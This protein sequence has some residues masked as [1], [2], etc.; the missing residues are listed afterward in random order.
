[1][2]NPGTRL[3]GAG[4]SA[5]IAMGKA[6]LVG[7]KLA[8][9]HE[10]VLSPEQTEVEVA[11]FE[12]ALRISREQ[13]AALQAR[14]Q[15]VMGKDNAA[16]FDSH[17]ML[18]DDP[19]VVQRVVEQIRERRRNAEHVFQS[20]ISG[21][22]DMLSK[23]D[24][25]YIRDRMADIQDVAGRVIRNLQGHAP[26]DLSH[27]QERCIVVAHE[28]SPSDTA[29]IDR[30]HVLAFVTAIGS[31]TS[32]TAIMAR[33]MGI[34][35]VVGLSDG[36]A[37]IDDG[38]MLVV[39][40]GRGEV[41]V[42]PTAEQ[43]ASSEQRIRDQQA[44]LARVEAE[45]TLPAE[46]LDGFHVRLAANIEMAEEVGTLRQRLGVGVGLFRTEFLFVR[47]DGLCEEEEHF[48]TYR[49]VAEDIYPHSVI[50]RT[51]DIGGDKFL[52]HLKMPVELNPFLGMRA[53][54]FCLRR[55][56]VFRVQ[57]RAILRA[58]AFGK[59]RIMFP[60]I[61]TL[62]ELQ[63]ALGLLS[64]VKA[65]LAAE[66]VPHNPHLDVGMMIEVPSAA[67]IADKLAP[68]V[69]FFSLGTNDLV[70]YS[71]AVDRSNPDLSY[72]YQPSHPSIIRMI[73]HVAQA[74]YAHGKWLGVCGEMASEPLL[75]PLLLGLGIHELSMSPVSIPTI[76][77]LVRHLRMH[78]AETLV[79]RAVGCG[80][81]EEVLVLCRDFI[82]R[83]SPDLLPGA[84]P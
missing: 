11:R 30:D 64:E 44:W 32:H 77:Q 66:G 46:T 14:V 17:L 34:P 10:V 18:V 81:A 60:M 43:L 49:K 57:L 59:V 5:G 2:A 19:S 25:S 75:V 1:M 13:I 71:L 47:N 70:Q 20:V 8:Q 9:V 58:S 27:L 21:Y 35:A 16:I 72:L 15:E 69:D 3:K 33:A 63:Q 26:I 65:E 12:T 79:D 24:D 38:D 73:Q 51:L 39:D 52:S 7:R 41:T 62:E 82:R 40:G 6:I 53:I 29:G 55:P 23:V 22:C 50:I 76:K 42:N 36:V 31:R 61:S 67:M 74:A 56:D 37:V 84:E 54:R 45:V 80:S 4:V 83:N 78:E 28:L 68:H 48:R